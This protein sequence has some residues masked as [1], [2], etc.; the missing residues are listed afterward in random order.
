MGVRSAD[1]TAA[2]RTVAAPRFAQLTHAS[3]AAADGFGGWRVK[4]ATGRIDTDEERQL[5]QRATRFD[6]GTLPRYLNRDE[7]DA[8]PRRVVHGPLDPTRAT[9]ATA[10]W[11]AVPAGFDSSSRPGNVFTHVVLD[12]R[13]DAPHPPM[14]PSDLL[15]SPVWLRPYGADQVDSA[16]LDGRPD[17]PWA[18]PALDRAAVLDF[19]VERALWRGGTLRALLDAVHGAM[20]QGPMVVLGVVD[21]ADADRWIAGVC[22]LMA[23][24]NSRHLYFST[25]AHADNLTAARDAGLHLVV[26]PAAELSEVERDDDNLVLLSDE[27][28]IDGHPAVE[29]ADFDVELDAADV[30][31]VHTTTYG[32]R[33]PATPWSVIADAVLRDPDL[34]AELLTRQDTVAAEVADLDVSCAWPLAIAVVE[35]TDRRSSRRGKVSHGGRVADQGLLDDALPAARMTARNAPPAVARTPSGATVQR[36]QEESLGQTAADAWAAL[37]GPLPHGVDRRRAVEVYLDRAFDDRDWLLREGGAPAFDLVGTR[38]PVHEVVEHAYA[39]VERFDT[40]PT[41]SDLDE[42]RAAAAVVLRLLDLVA[43]TGLARHLDPARVTPV[44]DRTVG[45]LLLDPVIGPDLVTQ[46]EPLAAAIQSRIVRPWLDDLLPRRGGRPGCRVAPLVL[47][48]LFPDPPDPLPPAGLARAAAL[49][50]TLVEAAAQATLVLPDPSAYRPTA[51]AAGLADGSADAARAMRGPGLPVAAVLAMLDVVEPHR[52]I[53]LLT[54]ALLAAPTGPDLDSLLQKL[55]RTTNHPEWDT[56]AGRMVRDACEL[57]TLELRWLKTGESP[58]E[59]SAVGRF[60]HLLSSLTDPASSTAPDGGLLRSA[61]AA[62]VVD[63]IAGT[64]E[65]DGPPLVQQRRPV[66]HWADIDAMTGIARR[67]AEAIRNGV[68]TDLRVVLAAQ[69]GSLSIDGLS[70]GASGWKQL[71]TLCWTTPMGRRENLLDHVIWLRVPVLRAERPDEIDGLATAVRNWVAATVEQ[72]PGLADPRR[73][74]AEYDRFALAW[75][76]RIGVQ[77]DALRAFQRRRWSS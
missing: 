19:L 5:V 11:H 54:P 36:V 67:I 44:L 23:P 20:E 69:L 15:R 46:V 32:S 6:V 1:A 34:A 43:R 56:T 21:P 26:V 66:S 51:V 10:Y 38:S 7:A 73:A 75:W 13:P 55:Q 68:T 22:H 18:D 33:I 24:A 27:D 39:A 4:Q 72:H 28:L 71:A 70:I 49:P 42:D 76:Y 35:R 57:R 63:R 25:T 50:A 3:V 61:M 31:Q 9:G 74:M 64:A 41:G 2:L 12:R 77:G 47:R 29:F 14:R 40:A 58:G 53:D 30:E 8:L 16:T 45:P 59:P 48:W 65:H 37:Q 17:P 60:I 52:L 62:D